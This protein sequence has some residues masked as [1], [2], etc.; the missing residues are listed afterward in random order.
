MD[1]IIYKVFV[2]FGKAI[3][4]LPMRGL[5]ILSDLLYPIVYYIIKYRRKVVYENLRNSFPEKSN[6][7]IEQIAKKFYRYFCDLLF[8]TIKLLHIPPD[9]LVRRF[10]F[11]DTSQ[12]LKEFE[13]K[14]HILAVLGHYGNWE[15]G[16]SLG[17]QIP[18]NFVGIYKPLTNKYFDELMIRLRTQY[19]CEAV[20][21]RQTARALNTYIQQGRLTILN[22]ITDQ[23]PYS[24]DIQYWTTFLNQDTPVLLGVEKFAKKTRQPVYYLSIIRVRRGY[25]EIEFEK[26]CDDCSTLENHEL[27][28]I[29]VKALEKLIRS[30][31]EYWLWTHRRWK[32]KR[33]QHTP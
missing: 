7:E 27:T 17:L 3:A 9:E 18:Y 33:E 25:Y 12:I 31:P 26:L 13:H 22:F 20:P 21:M 24:S 5:Y 2:S 6:K 19:G 8:E 11:R 16:L 28:E 10:K 30:A 32:N 15:W 1:Y 4:L 29:H 23:S 14:K